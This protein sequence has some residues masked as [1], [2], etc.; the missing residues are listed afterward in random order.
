MLSNGLTLY[1]P[2]PQNGQTRSNHWLF[3]TNSLIVL[4][5]FVGLALKGLN[6]SPY[7]LEILSLPQKL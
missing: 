7:T 1:A 3:P 5:D 2:A 6:A 4:D